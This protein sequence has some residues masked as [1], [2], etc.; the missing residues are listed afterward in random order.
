MPDFK[1][2]INRPVGG[3]AIANTRCEAPL[4]ESDTS[5]EYSS[6]IVK[7]NSRFHAESGVTARSNTLKNTSQTDITV[8][9]LSSFFT[10]S[11]APDFNNKDVLIHICNSAWQG[12]AQR[13]RR[14]PYDMGIYPVSS[15]GWSYTEQA[16]SSRGT[17]TTSKNHPIVLIE[18]RT[19]GKTWFF[20]IQSGSD[21]C[22][23]FGV[24]NRDG[25]Y[26]M[27]LDCTCCNESF[28]GFYKLLKPEEEFEV[29]T[30]LYGLA[31]SPEGASAQLI[32]YK[33]AFD[34]KLNIPYVCFNDYMNCLWG[35]PTRE[36]LI[37]LID[38]AAKAGAEVFCIDAGWFIND[39][40]EADFGDY[41]ENDK[42]FG[43]G[44]VRGILEYITSKNMKPGLW[45]ELETVRK[46]AQIVRLAPNAV[47]K[48]NG[49]PISNCS[50][51]NKLFLNF[52]CS[53][54]REYLHSRIRYFYDMGLRFIKNDYNQ[55]LKIGC[56]CVEDSSLSAALTEH[57][58]AFYSFIEELY[59]DMPDLIIENCGSGAMRCDN[60]TLRH[61]YLQ[62][63]SDQ[64]D[65]YNLPSIVRG[66]QAFMPP[67]KMGIWSYPYPALFD[68]WFNN[69]EALFNADYCASMA[70][71]EQTA[72]CMALTLFGCIYLS[73]HIEKCDSGN[74]ALI[75]K[76]IELY[77]ADRE[78]I[79]EALPVFIGEQQRLY[80]E[81]YSIIAL[82]NEEKLRIGIFRNGGDDSLELTVPHKFANGSLAE[83]YPCKDNG[84]TATLNNGALSFKTEKKLC[85]A[86]YEI[87]I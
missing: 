41:R 48:R 6:C 11:I 73:G 24:I 40:P 42:V 59:A 47:L 54:V 45:F 35:S 33:R 49:E 9:V 29:P 60:E 25:T 66:M 61:F 63:I 80:T 81:G 78:F 83:I 70:D 38:A 26:S 21:W 28:N 75:K 17:W 46:N 16:I 65:F 71:G 4:S 36:R 15:H 67:E 34:R 31:D 18:D 12:E 10:E 37:P 50:D 53:E 76:A 22:F 3:G 62:S 1:L 30:V 69:P 72:Y 8:S 5:A 14:T 77:K 79:K 7:K 27:T 74:F 56:D 44:G 52:A 51:E 19:D 57:T 82:K 55:T 20:E 13:C 64:E 86:V 32:T 58:R 43:E 85:A 84:R 2:I 68:Q 23:E 39:S 87:K